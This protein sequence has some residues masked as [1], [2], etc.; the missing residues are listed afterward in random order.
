MEKTCSLKE[1]VKTLDFCK[2]PAEEVL[3]G[4]VTG[5][6]RFPSGIALDL[7]FLCLGSLGRRAF[8]GI[9]GGGLIGD[10]KSAI[11]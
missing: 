10:V 11:N 6:R 1:G 3:V 9:K 4:L 2:L 5:K 8:G 7:L